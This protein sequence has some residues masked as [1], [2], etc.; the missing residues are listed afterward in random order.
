MMV[1]YTTYIEI[2]NWSMAIA[3]LLGA[4][5]KSQVYGIIHTFS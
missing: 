5:S 3:E 4:E 1:N 2:V